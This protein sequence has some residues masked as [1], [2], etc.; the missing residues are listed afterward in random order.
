MIIPYN[1]DSLETMEKITDNKKSWYANALYKNITHN[2]YWYINKKGYLHILRPC[3]VTMNQRILHYGIEDFML[4]KD[5][6]LKSMATNGI[7]KTI[8]EC[9]EFLNGQLINEV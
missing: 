1:N 2:I 8:E 4:T 7:Y 9:I 3:K 5:N 6:M